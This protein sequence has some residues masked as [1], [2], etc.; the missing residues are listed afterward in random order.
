MEL[1]T[2]FK[3]PNTVMTVHDFFKG[4]N[5]QASDKELFE[6]LGIRLGKP[7]EIQI[8]EGRFTHK[9]LL[10]ALPIDD[11]QSIF[12]FVKIKNK[13][14]RGSDH[15]LYTRVTKKEVSYLSSGYGLW[16]GRLKNEPYVDYIHRYYNM[17]PTNKT[18]FENIRKNAFQTLAFVVNNSDL[19]LRKSKREMYSH[20]YDDIPTV[21]LDKIETDIDELMVRCN[22]KVRRQRTELAESNIATQLN[23]LEERLIDL[24]NYYAQSLISVETTKKSH[25]LLSRTYNLSSVI[26]NHVTIKDRFERTIKT[27]EKPITV[28]DYDSNWYYETL[29]MCVQDVTILKKD[30][31]NNFSEIE[32][33]LNTV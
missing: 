7:M 18:E 8:I 5:F 29:A 15:I 2:S 13:I 4:C 23:M 33:L 20:L 26:H 31:E 14:Q 1:T 28:A 16:N 10:K 32:R 27:L 6:A 11:S 3:D 22:D 12:I 24:K 30:I 17:I 19:V 9:S 21:S 25:A